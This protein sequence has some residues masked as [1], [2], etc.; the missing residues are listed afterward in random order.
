MSAQNNDISANTLAIP[1]GTGYG[2][3]INAISRQGFQEAF[4]HPP[5]SQN[6]N[7]NNAADGEQR[8]FIGIITTHI[9]YH[10]NN[11]VQL[12][13]FNREHLVVS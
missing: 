12:I 13:F 10:H 2:T 3:L 7:L 6:M 11:L 1:S 4:I 5:G 8:G 9:T